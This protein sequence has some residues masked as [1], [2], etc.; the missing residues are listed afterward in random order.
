MTWTEIEHLTQQVQQIPPTQQQ[1]SQQ[2]S[3]VRM[4]AHFTM[5]EGSRVTVLEAEDTLYCAA[6]KAPAISFCSVWDS[7]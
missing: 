4:S 3:Q 7:W 2:L 6:A 5:M 1:T